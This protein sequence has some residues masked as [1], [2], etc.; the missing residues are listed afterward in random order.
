MLTVNSLRVFCALLVL[1]AGISRAQPSEPRDAWLMKNYRF[2]GP[3]PAGE[4]VQTDALTSQLRGIQNSVLAI[5]RK[6]NYDRDFETALAA[7]AQAAA[8]AQLIAAITDRLQPGT[9]STATPAAV[10]ADGPI[11]LI[12]SKDGTIGAATS[13]WAD[14][15]MLHYV[16]LQGAHV[17]VRLD[18]VDRRLS[19]ELNRQR[20][21]EFRFP[22]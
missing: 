2:T 4:F 12:A 14:R 20:N 11:F 10:R 1:S 15:F 5:L 22:E 6:A 13:Y 7:A 21:V 3:L 18:L 19:T 16:T 9:P 17:Q 8:N